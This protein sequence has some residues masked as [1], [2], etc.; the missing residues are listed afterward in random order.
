MKYKSPLCWIGTVFV[1]R[2]FRTREKPNC[3]SQL[4]VADCMCESFLLRG[5]EYYECKLDQKS[6][7]GGTCHGSVLGRRKLGLGRP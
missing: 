3:C 4:R 6:R 1:L 2:V 5:C 7:V